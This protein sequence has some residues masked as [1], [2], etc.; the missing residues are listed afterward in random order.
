MDLLRWK[1]DLEDDKDLLNDM[2]KEARKIT[3]NRDAKLQ[4]LKKLIKEKITNPINRDNKK[5]IIFSSFAD[6]AKYLYENISVYVKKEFSL[7]SALIT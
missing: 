2:I 5:F 7:E 3:V 1:Q 4:D 6:T